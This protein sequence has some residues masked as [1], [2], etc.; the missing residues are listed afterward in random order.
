MLYQMTV[1]YGFYYEKGVELCDKPEDY[2]AYKNELGRVDEIVRNEEGEFHEPL[3][4]YN[5]LYALLILLWSFGDWDNEASEK[6]TQSRSKIERALLQV[7][8]NYGNVS[9]FQEILNRFQYQFYLPGE[10]LFDK[11]K[12]KSGRT[13]MDSGFLTLLTRQLVLL[14]VYGIGDRTVI[15][16]LIGQLYTNLLLNRYRGD[17]KYAYLWSANN[18]E[19]FS[20]QRAV[21]ALTFY[22]KYVEA[23]E[24]AEFK[25]K[26]LHQE[27]NLIKLFSELLEKLKKSEEPSSVE[28]PK[29]PDHNDFRRI[30]VEKGKKWLSGLSPDQELFMLE[31][32]KTGDKILKTYHNGELSEEEALSLL[33]ALEKIVARP[34]VEDKPDVNSLKDLQDQLKKILTTTGRKKFSENP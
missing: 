9:I 22:Y 5:N 19:I 6:D 20:T 18:R 15:D 1:G 8:F 27:I 13:Y 16:P 32:K 21:Q 31:V 12:G 29:I 30:I 11:T 23:K 2:D 34:I 10:D 17:P 25:Q 28:I 14:G 26:S 7:V 4:L 24:S 33:I 3:A